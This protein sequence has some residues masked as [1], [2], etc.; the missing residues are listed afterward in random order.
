M[1]FKRFVRT[2]KKYGWS[3]DLF[4]GN[5]GVYLTLY[6]DFAIKSVELCNSRCDYNELLKRAIRTMKHY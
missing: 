4:G 3:F 1:L 5:E 2:C 6:S